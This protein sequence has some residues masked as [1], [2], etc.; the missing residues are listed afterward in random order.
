MEKGTKKFFW[1]K[2]K[3]KKN[4]SRKKKQYTG[5]GSFFPGDLTSSPL[6]GTVARSQWLCW[7]LPAVIKDTTRK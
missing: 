3:T 5:V 1:I 6:K 4:S 2:N 7:D